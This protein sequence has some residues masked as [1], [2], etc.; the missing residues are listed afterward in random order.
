[1][2]EYTAVVYQTTTGRV[3]YDIDLTEDPTWS[4]VL[5][6]VG[7]WQV[8]TPLEDAADRARCREWAERWFCS[9]AVLWDGQVCQAGPITENPDVSTSDGLP[10]LVVTG[11]GF[12]ENLNQ[13]LCHSRT[14]NPGSA[15]IT[16]SAADLTINDSLPNIARELMF[17]ATNMTV[18]QGSALPLDLPTAVASDANTR[19]Y[20]GYEMATFGQRLQELTQVD[21]GPDI[22]FQGYLTMVSGV[23]YVR[24]RALIGAPYLAQGGN[25]LL[26]DLGS[27]MAGLEV[28]GDNSPLIT[29]AFVKGTGN[30]AGQLYGYATSAGLIG[31][32]WPMLDYVDSSHGSAQV[33][34]TL[35]SWALADVAQFGRKLEQWK[36]RIMLSSEPKIGTYIPGHFGTY[37]INDHPWVPDGSF[38]AR[39]LGYS[40]AGSQDDQP[41]MIEHQIESVPT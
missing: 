1:M 40:S 32:G 14:W 13:R 3:L 9:V 6:G 35:D 18:R 39:I 25:P 10:T 12:W 37:V 34:S 28:Q 8:T 15:R 22:Y 31:N 41:A 21:G 30:E 33:Q 29:S 27:S 5:N 23:R 17:Q 36:P 26:F 19:T 38:T 24:H 2:P 11:K 4:A 16:S 20:R 7:T